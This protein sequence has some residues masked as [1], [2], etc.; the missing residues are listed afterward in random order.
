VRGIKEER[1]YYF[2]KIDEI[3]VTNTLGVSK[4]IY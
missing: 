2:E 3:L 4:A 1:D